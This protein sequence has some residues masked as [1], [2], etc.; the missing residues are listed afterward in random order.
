MIITI[1]LFVVLVTSIHYITLHY[2]ICKKINAIPGPL[3]LPILGNVYSLL[4]TA[5]DTW[6]FLRKLS[7]EYFPIYQIW[8]FTSSMINIVH[9]DAIEAV[10]GN[11][12]FTQKS[13]TYIFMHPWLGSGLLTTSGA[14]WQAR[15]KMLTPAFHFNIL[16]QFVE[17]FIEQ[18]NELVQTLKN[19]KG[20]VV[21]D[22]W[23]LIS[24][25]TLNIICETAMGVSLKDKGEFQH[26]YRNAVH[27]MGRIPIYRFTRP[28]FYNDIVFNLCPPGW[29]QSRLLK[30]LHGFTNKIIDER[31][32]Y[33]EETNN[34]YI[35]GFDDNSC[36]ENGNVEIAHSKRRLAML[37]LL[38]AAHRTNQIDDAGIRDEVETFMFKGHDTTAMS[39][40][41]TI[42]LFAEHP[43]IQD[44]ARAEVKE[45]MEQNN[46]KLNMSAIQELS[47]LERC[48]KESL[49]LYPS[50]PGIGRLTEKSVKLNNYE[51]PAGVTINV[52]IFDT[53]RDPRL[54]PN[55]EV[56]DPDRFLPEN[57]RGRH[58]YSYIPFSAGPRNCI[59][60]KFAM[61]EL[62]VTLAI[63]LFNFSFQPVDYLKN[64]KFNLDMVLRPSGS[65]RTKIIP[66]DVTI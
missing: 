36:Q 62:K 9:P 24:E 15:R 47:Y 13:M 64:I 27:E 11:P 25:H 26:K 1:L 53:H 22:L 38:I 6:I 31:K 20:P 16:R 2:V 7:R 29:R 43:E 17:I 49:R 56:F 51:V 63:L 44:R 34:R 14:M 21:K 35:I 42:M 61:L 33:H 41:F 3:A 54:W 18:G 10:L 57:S 65:I 40:C 59:G 58:P 52:H 5:N 30:I 32:Q 50:V 66:L 12:K 55:P 39:L 23:P 28:W 46:G 19:E 4:G 48:I 8:T 37:D 45:V 60:R